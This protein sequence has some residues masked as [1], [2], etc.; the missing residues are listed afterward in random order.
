MRTSSKKK[1]HDA[2]SPE[3]DYEIE[4]SVDVD[5]I[6]KLLKLECCVCHYFFQFNNQLHKH[7]YVDCSYD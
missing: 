6:V 1:N 5:Y 4:N 7:L 2:V 3:K